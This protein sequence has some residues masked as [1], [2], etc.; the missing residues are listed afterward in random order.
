[1]SEVVAP[2]IYDYLDYRAF[3][4]D[5]I[6]WLKQYEALSDRKLAERGGFGS[7]SF[8]KMLCDGR[9]RLTTKN[10]VAVSK[11]LG[12][13]LRQTKFLEALMNFVHADGLD[14]KNHCFAEILQFKKYR[15]AHSVDER[16]FNFFSQWWNVAIYEALAIP[17]WQQPA[18]F[19][20]LPKVLGIGDKQ[21]DQSLELLESLGFIEKFQQS[22]RQKEM[23]LETKSEVQSLVVRNF[24]RQMILRA[25]QAIEHLPKH[26]R[27]LGSLTIALSPEDFASFKKELYEFR[28]EANRKY[29]GNNKAKV[30]YQLCFQLFP[31]FQERDESH[32]ES[33]DN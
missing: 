25:Q 10:L 6:A 31:L 1:M 5:Q 15:A 14:E 33:E 13:D 9:R 17:Y 18:Q 12:L 26:E 29:S 21:F 3:M 22:F 11:S 20:K 27:D 32:L 4:R 2:N 24:H 30:V 8:L 28:S 23:V 16:Y 19:K 7:P